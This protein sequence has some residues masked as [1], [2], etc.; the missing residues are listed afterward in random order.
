VADPSFARQTVDQQML[1]M[2][3]IAGALIAGV[4]FFL[5]F[6][7]FQSPLGQPPAGQQ[8]SLMAVGFAVINTLL[9]F[10]VPLVVRTGQQAGPANTVEQKA[11]ALFF[12]RMIV[13]LALLEGAAFFN[14]FS[15]MSEH[16][17]WTLVVIGVLVLLML[18][19][20]PTRTRFEQFIENQRLEASFRAPE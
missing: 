18:A 2:R 16:N 15:L 3:I 4:G 5:A 8:T 19:L 6:V 1:V 7:L 14:I 12:T 10:G 17:W 11:A 9:Q 13:R 20:W